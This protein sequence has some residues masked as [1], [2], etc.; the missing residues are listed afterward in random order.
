MFLSNGKS[1]EE[2][3]C[4]TVLSLDP[5]LYLKKDYAFLQL[6][7]TGRLYT[8]WSSNTDFSGYFFIHFVQDDRLSRLLMVAC[9]GPR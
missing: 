8:A 7:D 9:A 1:P 4:L 3:D 5:A 2:S 6:Y